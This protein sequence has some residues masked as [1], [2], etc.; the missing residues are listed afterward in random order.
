MLCEYYRGVSGSKVLVE[1]LDF[2][3]CICDHGLEEVLHVYDKQESPFGC[4]DE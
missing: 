3:D 4:H 2:G 1:L